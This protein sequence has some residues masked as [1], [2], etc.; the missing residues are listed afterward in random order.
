M[1]G[2]EW[3]SVDITV[4]P[5]NGITP[6]IIYCLQILSINDSLFIFMFMI[7]FISVAVVTISLSSDILTTSQ[8]DTDP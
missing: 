7:I 5:R 3:Y 6:F 8:L 1:G 4:D 2:V